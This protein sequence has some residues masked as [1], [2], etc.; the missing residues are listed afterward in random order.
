MV[1]EIKDSPAWNDYTKE[2]LFPKVIDTMGF[3]AFIDTKSRDKQEYSNS[4]ATKN[5]EKAWIAL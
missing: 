1:V 4:N 2:S 5:I 3:I